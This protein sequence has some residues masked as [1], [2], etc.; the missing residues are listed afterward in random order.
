MIVVVI[1]SGPSLTADDCD[2][3]RK[4]GHVTIAVNSSWQA[5]PWANIV[6]AADEPWWDFNRPPDTMQK[7]TTSKEAAR[8]YRINRFCGTMGANSGMQA[9]SLALLLGA[10]K[11]VLIGFDA[12]L[13]NGSH[14]HGDHKHTSNPTPKS[15]SQWKVQFSQLPT[16][17]P[18]INCS[19]YTELETFKRGVLE[20]EI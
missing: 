19:R 6:F 17:V 4:A 11:I 8:K 10:S 16:R 13:K 1:G 3:I 9:I 18:I 20:D 14:W 5:A 15:I 7:W 2:L 12:S